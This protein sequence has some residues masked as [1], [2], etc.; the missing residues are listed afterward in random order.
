MH[1]RTHNIRSL[2]HSDCQEVVERFT[3]LCLVDGDE[4]SVHEIV[5]PLLGVMMR[6]TLGNFIV[7]MRKGKI[8]AT[9]MHIQMGLKVKRRHG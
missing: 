5:A 8:L 2:T 7:M 9:R 4:T 6:F 3:H 1:T